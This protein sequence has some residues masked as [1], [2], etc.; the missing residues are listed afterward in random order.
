MAVL[1]KG[2]KPNNIDSHNSLAISVRDYLPLIQKASVTHSHNLAA[3]V[4]E[5][6]PFA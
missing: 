3:Y 2:R 4:K 5:G 1:S 6:L